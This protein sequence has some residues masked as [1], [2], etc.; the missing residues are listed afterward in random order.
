[1]ALFRSPDIGLDLGTSTTLAYVRGKGIVLREPTVIAVARGSGQLRALG[2]D[3]RKILGREDAD[4]IVVRPLSGG[5][6]ANFDATERMLSEYFARLFGSRF[7]NRPRVAV[8]VPCN[9]SEVDMRAAIE[10]SEGAGA[11]YTYLIYEPV[12]AAIG[13]GLDIFS[14]EGRLLLDIG[15]GTSD[16]VLLCAGHVV[17]QNSARNGGD[18]MDLAIARYFKRQH[19]IALGERQAEALK[20]RYGSAV[21]RREEPMMPVVGRSLGGGLPVQAEIGANALVHALA[22]PLRSL[23]DQIKE[24]LENAPPELCGEVAEN[25]IVLTGGG[26]L[27]PGIDAY[28]SEQTGLPCH[29]AEDPLTCVAAGAGKAMEEFKRYEKVLIDYHRGYYFE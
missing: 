29:I 21:A 26:A 13:M 6:I 28:L 9:A 1:M 11:R 14:P 25:G 24:L 22:E 5:V 27:L 2:E 17:L 4:T 3:A 7:W 23:A 16:A 20:I 12:A 18:A 10:T 8:A 15:A 19:G